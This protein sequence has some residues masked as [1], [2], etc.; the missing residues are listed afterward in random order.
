M[1][2][3]LNKFGSEALYLGTDFIK[4]FYNLTA[5][6]VDLRNGNKQ[7]VVKLDINITADKSR[8]ADFP[9]LSLHRLSS[10]RL[11]QSLLRHLTLGKGISIPCTGGKGYRFIPDSR[12]R[13]INFAVGFLFLIELLELFQHARSRRNIVLAAN[14]EHINAQLAAVITVCKA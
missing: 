5:Q 4:L 3:K 10:C 12:E 8:A 13:K 2:F 9:E 7:T 11:V 14:T 1:R 6:S